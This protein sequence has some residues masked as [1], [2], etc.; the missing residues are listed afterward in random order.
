VLSA[1][2]VSVELTWS[3]PG[4][5]L[6]AAPDPGYEASQLGLFLELY[7]KGR[8]SCSHSRPLLSL[9]SIEVKDAHSTPSLL[10][11]YIY[12]GMKPVIWSP[13]SRTAL[14]EAEVE[15]SDTHVSPSIYVAFPI[16]SFGRDSFLWPAL[17]FL[18]SFVRAQSTH[19]PLPANQATA[20][21]KFTNVH[22]LIWTTT[23]WTIPANM[24]NFPAP[25]CQFCAVN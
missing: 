14:A 5:V 21:S 16:K 7:K 2:N 23:P 6:S 8:R 4:L 9:S 18:A 19:S 25:P 3:E 13:S 10:P 12:R 22:A 11:G 24:V 1:L 15:Y 17:W 20:L